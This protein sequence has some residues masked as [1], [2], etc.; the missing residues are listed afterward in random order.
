LGTFPNG[1]RV[2][3]SRAKRLPVLRKRR[4]KKELPQKAKISREK[5]GLFG[6]HVKRA[7]ILCEEKKMKRKAGLKQKK[8]QLGRKESREKDRKKKGKK[9]W[10]TQTQGNSARRENGKGL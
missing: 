10:L 4:V 7:D 9:R 2:I 1:K 8:I 6:L 5:K 3:S